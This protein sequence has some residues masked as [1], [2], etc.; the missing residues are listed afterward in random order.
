MV[1]WAQ[2]LTGSWTVVFLGYKLY[3]KK[4]DGVFVNE[5][6]LMDGGRG[7]ESEWLIKR[8][9]IGEKKC[10]SSIVRCVWAPAGSLPQQWLLS[11]MS[12]VVDPRDA[13]LLKRRG[14]GGGE[15]KMR[16]CGGAE[17]N[18]GMETGWWWV[19]MMPQL[20]WCCSQTVPYGDS[21][22]PSRL[23]VAL[24]SKMDD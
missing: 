16:G 12:P 18:Q 4:P 21:N 15:D 22:K 1:Q 24:L 10:F 17:G 11:L 13:S 7:E 6:D 23:L 5:E 20:V 3:R 14:E 2:I 9:T 8:D 19:Q